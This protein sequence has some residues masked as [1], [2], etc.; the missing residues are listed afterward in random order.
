MLSVTSNIDDVLRFTDRFNRN[1]PFAV[2]SALTAS[3]KAAQRAMPAAVER[4]L[5]D[6]TAFTK[7]G[8]YIVPARKDNL[9]AA[10]GVKD[11]QAEY[12][13]Y[14]VEGGSRKPKRRALRLPTAVDLDAHGNVPSGLIRQ[15]VTRARA[16][17]R[18]TKAQARRFGVSQQVDLFY[19]DPGDDRPAG[20][21]KRVAISST[22]HRLIPLIVFPQQEAKYKPRFDFRGA[23][24]R[25]VLL[26]FGPALRRSWAQAIASSTMKERV[27]SLIHI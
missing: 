9:V 8:F 24:K 13:R 6:P 12:L 7:G 15:L 16:G 2:A 23:A 21:Y 19:G 20:I 17:K 5:E 11:K 22:Q 3:V 4:D 27:L 14:Q 26:A 25:E 10:V 18:A 1:Y